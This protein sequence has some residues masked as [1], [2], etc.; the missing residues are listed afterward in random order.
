MK[1]KS[2]QEV[3]AQR[4]GK[5]FKILF[6]LRKSAQIDKKLDMIEITTNTVK[7]RFDAQLKGNVIEALNQKVL[8]RDFF[9]G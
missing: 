3:I 4:K 8:W 7:D 2:G 6:F 9:R 5:E 1:T